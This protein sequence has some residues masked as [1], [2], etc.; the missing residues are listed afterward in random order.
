MISKSRLRTSFILAIATKPGTGVVEPCGFEQLHGHLEHR[1][2]AESAAALGGAVK[3]AL[4]ILN[5]GAVGVLPIRTSGEGVE[6]ILRAGWRYLKYCSVAGHAGTGVAAG[7]AK[8]IAPSTSITLPQDDNRPP[9]RE[10]VQHSK[11]P[12]VTCAGRQLEY[13]TAA[14]GAKRV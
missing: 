3:I 7:C 11:A 4:L 1:A 13:G 9:V 6:H 10:A 14:L 5:Q 8:D 12:R 2:V